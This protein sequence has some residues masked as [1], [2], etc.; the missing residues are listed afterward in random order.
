MVD[1]TARI[2]IIMCEVAIGAG[3]LFVLLFMV[4]GVIVTPMELSDKVKEPR[5]WKKGEEALIRK[6]GQDALKVRKR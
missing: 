2:V 3:I 5:E 4:V 6:H 1:L